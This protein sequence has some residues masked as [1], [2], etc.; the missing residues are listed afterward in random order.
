MEV[1]SQY[2]EISYQN[3]ENSKAATPN[4]NRLVPTAD[5]TSKEYYRHLTD[6]LCHVPT[7]Q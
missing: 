6:S 3:S 5:M 4:G 1:F 2:R 7:L